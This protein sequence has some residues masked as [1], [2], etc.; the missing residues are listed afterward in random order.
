MP[1]KPTLT[2]TERN[3]LWQDPAHW[4]RFGSYRCAEDPRLMVPFRS[5]AGLTVNM[6]HRRAQQLLWGF[7]AVVIALVVGV[8]VLARN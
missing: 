2:K 5:G 6:G 1:G 7:L 8:A 3:A 4:D